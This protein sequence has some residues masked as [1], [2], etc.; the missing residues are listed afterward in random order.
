MHQPGPSH[1]LARRGRVDCSVTDNC[2]ESE[3]FSETL[4]PSHQE[5]HIV[6]RLMAAVYQREPIRIMQG[7][8]A[9]ARIAP[10]HCFVVHPNPLDTRG[11]LTEECRGFLIEAVR[12]A[13]TTTRFRMCLVWAP[14]SC[15]FVEPDG[16]VRDS[17]EPPSGGFPLPFRIAFDD[18]RALRGDA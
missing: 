6:V 17:S 2:S 12:N 10:G 9:R 16:S 7:P 1:E 5:P 11:S 3:A 13:V 8:H 14:T 4:C 18:R 15:S